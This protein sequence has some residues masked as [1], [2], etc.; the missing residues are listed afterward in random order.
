MA[1]ITNNKFMLIFAM[2]VRQKTIKLMLIF[3]KFIRY[4]VFVDDLPITLETA[5]GPF[6]SSL[7]PYPSVLDF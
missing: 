5:D 2:F 4:T 1:I 6:F 7:S 3:A